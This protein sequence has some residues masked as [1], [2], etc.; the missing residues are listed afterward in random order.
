MTI[1]KIIS[2][3]LSVAMVALSTMGV[4]QDQIDLDDSLIDS[5]L[6]DSML[7]AELLDYEAES[8]GC[9]GLVA[10]QEKLTARPDSLEYLFFEPGRVTLNI[11]RSASSAL[12]RVESGDAN[13]EMIGYRV[14]IFFSNRANGRAEANDVVERCKEQFEDIK[15]TLIYDN[16][17][18]KVHAG[19]A[20]S[21]EE[22]VMMLNR[23]Q[24]IFPKAYI[25]RE[26]M[27]PADLIV[28]NVIY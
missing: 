9:G 8:V 6:I 21:N 16:P 27:T 19:Y 23:L 25:I 7:L 15:T 12:E 24:K 4:A 26:K 5:V 2:L 17:Y 28:E 13:R 14:G 11:D 3:W 22:A 18:F 10:Y 1:K 20:T